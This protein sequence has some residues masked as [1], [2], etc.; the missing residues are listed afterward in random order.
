MKRQERSLEELYSGDPERADALLGLD[1]GRRRVLRVIGSAS[2]ALLLSETMPFGTLRPK[3]L[4]PVVLAQGEKP[5]AIEGKEGLV[6]L[7]DRPINAETPI[8]LLDDEVTPNHRHYIRNNGL[9]PE[10]AVKR[11]LT[12]WKLTIDGEVGTPLKVDLADLKARYPHQTLQLQ[13]ECAGN[14]RAGFRPPATGL[15]WKMGSVGCAMYTGVRLKDVL[16]T[17]GIK[18]TAVYVGYYGEDVHLSGDPSAVPISRGVPIEK[19]MD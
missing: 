6:L 13:L 11:D 19:A 12:G 10:R 4:I 3:G 1:G 18:S 5:F 17:A 8:S 16:E 15:Q 14:G 7:S 2:A 9:V